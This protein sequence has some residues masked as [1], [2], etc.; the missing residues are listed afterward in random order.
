M[1]E[2][3]VA[4]SVSWTRARRQAFNA[5]HRPIAER[6]NFKRR[7]AAETYAAE[8]RRQ[9]PTEIL[10]CVTPIFPSERAREKQRQAQ[11]LRMF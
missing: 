9:F 11:Q 4:W 5:E 10:V 2:T 6:Q 1:S 3:P 8:L 7:E